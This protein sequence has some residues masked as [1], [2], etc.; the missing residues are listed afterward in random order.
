MNE[1][2]IGFESEGGM[3]RTHR[4]GELDVL[5]TV[6]VFGLAFFHTVSIFSGHQLITNKTQ[7]GLITILASLLV[8]SEFIWI[9][10]V[11]M[12]VAGIAVRYSLERRSAT[13]FL[14][15]R[16][17]R[18]GVPFLTGL[19]LVNPPQVYYYLKANAGL[20]TGFIT[21]LPRY[22]NIRF[23]LLSFPYFLEP[24]GSEETFSVI[25][26]WFLIFLLVYTLLLLPLFLYLKSP[27]GKRLSMR[28]SGFLSRRFAV[29]LWAVPI[30]LLEAFLGAIWPS[31]WNR[32]IWPFIILFGY[33]S[34]ADDRLTAAMVRHRIPALVLGLVGF[35]GFFVGTGML[36]GLDIDPWAGHEGPAIILRFIKGSGSWCLTIA[37][38][39]MATRIGQRKAGTLRSAQVQPTPETPR[40]PDRPAFWSR[41]AAYGRE[42]Q[43][44]FYVLH[45]TPIIVIG[46]YVVDWNWPALAKFLIIFLGSLVSA[47]LVYELLVRRIGVLRLLFGMKTTTRGGPANSI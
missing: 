37:I 29:F 20:S 8:S 44:P 46:Y 12:L 4:R 14:R 33:L 23:S 2:K 11:M 16:F 47:L 18:L 17:L 28:V 30:A 41:L 7:S 6:I 15:E 27:S 13:R 25:H 10:P 19:V 24:A 31:G 43:L 36:V 42:A 1:E 40:S 5:T 21:F 26:L 45:Q 38:V 39:G 34:A 9:M 35:L 3:I 32:W 22:W